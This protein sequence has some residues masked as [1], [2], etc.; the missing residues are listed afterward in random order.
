VQENAPGAG[1]ETP[2]YSVDSQSFIGIELCAWRECS[3][4]NVLV[5]VCNNGYVLLRVLPTHG[6]PT[7]KQLKW[8]ETRQQ[9]ILAITL[10]PGGEW[11]ACSCLDGGLY[12]VPIISLTL[13]CA[14]VHSFGVLDDVTI[15][16]PSK[17]IA[18]PTSIVWWDTM[19]QRHICITGS[20][21]TG[22]GDHFL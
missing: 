7:I 5:L 9:H 14:P 6:K 4:H 1:G 15:I 21:A 10:D 12:L 3:G 13:E 16:Q 2:S 20:E 19:D 18:S 11:L 17:K 22:W 8:Y